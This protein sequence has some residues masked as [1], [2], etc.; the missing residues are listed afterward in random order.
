[1]QVVIDIKKEVEEAIKPLFKKIEELENKLFVK[2]DNLINR[3]EVAKMLNV[4]P[5]SID[6]WDREGKLPHT[7]KIGGKK[8]WSLKKI[9][10]KQ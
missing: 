7:T 6:R 3:Q 1:M 2:N 9:I 10:N 8:Y 5:E 4:K